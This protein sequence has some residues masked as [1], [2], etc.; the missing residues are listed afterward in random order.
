MA[1]VNENSTQYANV[2]ADPIVM[3]EQNVV[4][5]PV[6]YVF[7]ATRAVQGDAGSLTKLLKLPAGK[8]R[9]IG[10]WLKNSALGSSR[11][12]SLGNAAYVNKAGTAV[13]AAAASI[14]AAYDASGAVDAYK[15]F[16][17]ADTMG[18]DFETRD[19]LVVEATV[20]GGT[21]DAGE[22]LVGWIDVMHIG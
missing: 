17:D 2:I 12:L 22:T 3:N 20:A 11:T 16:G 18:V 13:V 14:L 9:I 21:H 1:A 5:R 10:G 6:R 19:G 7:E 15:V 4:G 8:L